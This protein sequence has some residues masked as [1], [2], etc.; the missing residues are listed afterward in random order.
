MYIE[1]SLFKAETLKL[2]LSEAETASTIG[3]YVYTEGHLRIF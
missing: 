3:F 2:G 1:P